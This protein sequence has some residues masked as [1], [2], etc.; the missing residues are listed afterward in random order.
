MVRPF[1]RDLRR[2][3]TFTID[4]LPVTA[5]DPYGSPSGPPG[6]TL[7]ARQSGSARTG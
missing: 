7:D 1:T 4:D 5:A 3:R 6:G 2:E